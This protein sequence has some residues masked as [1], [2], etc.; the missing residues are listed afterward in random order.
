MK[1]SLS[2]LAI[3]FLFSINS[4]AKKI[5][6]FFITTGGDT[7]H[8]R[9]NVRVNLISQKIKIERIQNKIKCYDSLNTKKTLKPD[10]A[11]EL[12]IADSSDTVRMLSRT[13]NLGLGGASS[14]KFIFLKIITDGNLKLFK[15]YW[16]ESSTSYSITANGAMS[17]S[18][19]GEFEDWILQKNDEPLFRINSSLSFRRDIKAY[20]SD[21]P[22]LV[23]RIEERRYRSRN[24]ALIVDLYNNDC[25]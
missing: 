23:K 16:S 4:D 10:M 3:L 6:G 15:Y 22:E 20:L 18:T 9:F 25:K 21:C 17:G 2:F 8:V 12:V 19:Y 1:I 14:G 13:N 5:S 7:V 24:M 11:K